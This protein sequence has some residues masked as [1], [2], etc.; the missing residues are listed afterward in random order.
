MKSFGISMSKM[1]PALLNSPYL[2]S[3]KFK[4]LLYL[5]F[6]ITSESVCVLMFG[7]RVFCCVQD[8]G[9]GAQS[10]LIFQQFGSF[11]RCC[12]QMQNPQQPREAL[13]RDGPGPRSV[14]HTLS[15]SPSLFKHFLFMVVV[16]F[17]ILSF[18]CL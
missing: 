11:T 13:H 17:L 9:W 3:V 10:K 2:P 18:G 16:M 8:C 1:Y 4:L 15:F 5:M 6:C 14:S 7:D 12:V